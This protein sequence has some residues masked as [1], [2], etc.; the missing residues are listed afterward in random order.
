MFARRYAPNET[1]VV[2]GS[3][4]FAV[5]AGLVK[6]LRR[7]AHVIVLCS[8]VGRGVEKGNVYRV[9]GGGEGDACEF[10]GLMGGYV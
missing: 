4:G 3:C 7:M 8:R 10:V 1:S 2:S 9:A 5:L 6:G